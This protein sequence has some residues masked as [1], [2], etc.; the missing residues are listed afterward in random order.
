M[1]R[2]TDIYMR[3]RFSVITGSLHNWSKTFIS[4]QISISLD[5]WCLFQFDFTTYMLRLEVI[6]ASFQSFFTTW[7]FQIFR[8]KGQCSLDHSCSDFV[9]F[10]EWSLHLHLILG[11]IGPEPRLWIF[12]VGIGFIEDIAR[13]SFKIVSNVEKPAVSFIIIILSKKFKLLKV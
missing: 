8:F 7:S 4:G 5:S 12:F 3:E 9:T 2:I 1:Y 11:D 10:F 13:N 6:R